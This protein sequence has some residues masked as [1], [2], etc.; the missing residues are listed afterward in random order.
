MSHLECQNPSPAHIFCAQCSLMAFS[1][2][3]SSATQTESGAT[4]QARV[5]VGVLQLLNNRADADDSHH[6]VR[7]RE[8]FVFQVQ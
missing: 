8:F 5:E 7:M 2:N 6:I 3:H 1:G 4:L